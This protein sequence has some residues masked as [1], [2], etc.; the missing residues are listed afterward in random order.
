[1]TEQPATNS[2]NEEDSDEDEM[3]DFVITASAMFEELLQR[4]QPK[5]LQSQLVKLHKQSL[6]FLDEQWLH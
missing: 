1:M 3:I 6:E 4:P 2:W 5:Y